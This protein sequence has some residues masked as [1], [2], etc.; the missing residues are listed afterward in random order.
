MELIDGDGF[1]FAEPVR[2]GDSSK[3][4]D[5]SGVLFAP[6]IP[7]GVAVEHEAVLLYVVAPSGKKGECYDSYHAI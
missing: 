2:P 6:V 4:I 5:G 7:T 3:D 1:M